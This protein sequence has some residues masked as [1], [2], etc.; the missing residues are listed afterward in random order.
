M[1]SDTERFAR[2]FD[3]VIGIPGSKLGI[4]LD[5]IIGFVFPVVG[6]VATGLAS[7][8]VPVQAIRA[9]VPPIIV[10]RMLVNITLDEFIGWF[11]I[12]GDIADVFFQSNLMN[13]ELMKKHAGGTTPTTSGDWLYVFGTLT[14]ALVVIALPMLLI[15]GLVWKLIH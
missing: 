2:L 7:L 13:L 15:T 14:L 4:G 11:P 3:R 5:P 1:L 8:Y 6:D 12:A 9:R 10:A